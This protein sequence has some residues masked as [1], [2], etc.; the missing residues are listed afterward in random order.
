MGFRKDVSETPGLKAA[1]RQGLQALKG[2]DRKRIT[3]NDPASLAG[4]VDLDSSLRQGERSGEPVWDYVIAIKERAGERL[5]WVEVHPAHGSGKVAEMEKKL[6]WL[7]QWLETDGI[8]LNRAPRKIIWISSGRSPMRR[9]APQLRRLAI[10]GLAFVGAH[11]H[12]K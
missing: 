11:Y 3:V 8:K 12:L 6:E 9:G 4:S 5:D 2:V 1:Y 10:K 7:F